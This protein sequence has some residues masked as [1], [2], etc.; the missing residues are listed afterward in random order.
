MSPTVLNNYQHIKLV[1]SDLDGTLLGNFN[2]GTMTERTVKSLQDLENKGIQIVL[3]SGRPPRSFFPLAAKANLKRPIIIS[4]NGGL[5]LDSKTKEVIR[6][7]SIATDSVR[8]LIREVKTHFDPKDILIGGESGASFRCE[9][10][11]A[12]KRRTWVPKNYVRVD[13]LDNF[14][15]EEHTIEKLMLLHREWVA[16]DLYNYLKANVLTDS[17]WKDMIHYTFSSPN[18]VEV[19]AVGVCKATA[20]KDVCEELGVKREEVIAFGDMPNDC[21]MIEYAGTGVAMGNA[22]QQVKEIAGK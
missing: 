9:E 16:E 11:Y 7:Y 22:H 18:F 4:C 2:G 21:E 15:T 17:K 1:A 14:A 13:D 3:A 12:E 19:S 10:N 20:L 6:K 8:E 5:V